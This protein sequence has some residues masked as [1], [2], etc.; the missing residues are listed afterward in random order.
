MPGFINFRLGAIKRTFKYTVAILI[1]AVTM[2]AC[3]NQDEET[4]PSAP[5][6]QYDWVTLEQ[7]QLSTALSV[8]WK[9]SL[10]VGQFAVAEDAE[11][12]RRKVLSLGLNPSSIIPVVDKDGL[13]W[14]IVSVGSFESPEDALMS[15]PRISLQL[16]IND[17]PLIRLPPSSQTRSLFN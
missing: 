1:I 11:A 12:T 7:L 2:T 13:Y 9:Y 17:L 16:G 5:Q 10:Q 14:F 4:K 8:N 15:S 3:G 6:E